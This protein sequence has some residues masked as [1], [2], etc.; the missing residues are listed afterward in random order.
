MNDLSPF[1]TFSDTG[2]GTGADGGG[3][4]G[5][6]GGA[7][8]VAGAPDWKY[9][10]LLCGIGGIVGLCGTTEAIDVLRIPK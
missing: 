4:A 9:V 10:F 2:A 5:A 8:G 6:A 1:S 7:D 3:G